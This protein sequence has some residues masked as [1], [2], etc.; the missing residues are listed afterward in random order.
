[1]LNMPKIEI[2]CQNGQYFAICKL[3]TLKKVLEIYE[4][5]GTDFL[6][7]QFHRL[8]CTFTNRRIYE[9]CNLIYEIAGLDF[10]SLQF[11]RW[12]WS[13]L[14]KMIYEIAGTEFLAQNMHR[15]CDFKHKYAQI[16][17]NISNIEINTRFW[18]K[19]TQI[20]VNM[21]IFR[22]IY[23]ILSKICSFLSKIYSIFE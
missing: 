3:R 8:K 23:S 4:I 22:A 21:L 11:H 14:I 12:K 17:R 9:K 15:I 2:K 18:A 13:F 19:Y 10:L 20:W 16:S 6:S 1:M 5:A 7:L